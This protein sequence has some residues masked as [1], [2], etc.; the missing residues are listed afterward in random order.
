MII[1]SD[2]PGEYRGKN[3]L[4]KS[5]EKYLT[6]INWIFVFEST[7]KVGKW[8]GERAKLKVKECNM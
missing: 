7:G 1:H 8:L 2:F 6:E 5:R 3:T 4:W